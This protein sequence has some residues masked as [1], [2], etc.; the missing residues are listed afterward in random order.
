MRGSGKSYHQYVD[1]Y[2]VNAL[3]T[4]LTTSQ[5]RLCTQPIR[6]CKD[7]TINVKIRI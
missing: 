5:S 7:G 2:Q 1:E 3:S 6:G 4:N